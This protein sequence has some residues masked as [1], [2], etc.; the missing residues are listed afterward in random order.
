MLQFLQLLLEVLSSFFQYLDI[1]DEI[2]L[3]GKDEQRGTNGKKTHELDSEPCRAFMHDL[4]FCYEM[5]LVCHN[6][7]LRAEDGLWF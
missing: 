2:K 4:W 5:K 7:L 1:K 3:T 6:K